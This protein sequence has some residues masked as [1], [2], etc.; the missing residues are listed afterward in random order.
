MQRVDRT[1]TGSARFAVFAACQSQ[2]WCLCCRTRYAHI[3]A[4]PV[5]EPFALTSALCRGLTLVDA[6][7]AHPGCP[8]CERCLLKVAFCRITSCRTW[9]TRGTRRTRCSSCARKTSDCS[10]PTR[11]CH[12]NRWRQQFTSQGSGRKTR[13]KHGTRRQLCRDCVCHA[14]SIPS[15]LSLSPRSKNQARRPLRRT[16]GSRPQSQ[17]GRGSAELFTRGQ[18]NRRDR[19]NKESSNPAAK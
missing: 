15:P 2:C 8:F 5:S 1:S 7:A 16:L 4:F 9:L 11:G 12:R 17:D 10:R 6:C 13:W 14:P 3:D 19:I 18:Q